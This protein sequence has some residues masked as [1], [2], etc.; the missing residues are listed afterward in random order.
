MGHCSTWPLHAAL[1]VE[2]SLTDWRMDDQSG[3]HLG[4]RDGLKNFR[5]A[6]TPPAGLSNCVQTPARAPAKY[7]KGTCWPGE[8]PQFCQGLEVVSLA[9]FPAC[10]PILTGAK[11][12]T[13]SLNLTSS[14]GENRPRVEQGQS[15]PKKVGG[16]AKNKQSR[17]EGKL[18]SQ[19]KMEKP[20]QSTPPQSSASDRLKHPLL[21]QADRGIQL[22][23]RIEHLRVPPHFLV[24]STFHMPWSHKKSRSTQHMTR[25]CQ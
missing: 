17:A 25:I 20:K 11:W 10:I 24:G 21:A 15:W 7:C 14:K 8:L 9:I 23:Q 5:K 13:C 3:V 22:G 1:K 16:R 19:E 6:N 4:C 18:P 2:K 12:A